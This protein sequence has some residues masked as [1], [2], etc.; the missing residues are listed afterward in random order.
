[1]A[2]KGESMIPPGCTLVRPISEGAFGRVLEIKESSTGKSYA[3]KLIPRLTEADQKR[4]E[5]EVSLLERFR[6]ARIVG[7]H[8]SVV[9]ETYH[10]IVMDLGKRN[11]KDLMIEYESRKKLI[12]LEVAV[13]ISIDI[14]EGLCVMHNHPTHPMAH[15]DLKPE[16]VLL[17]EDNRAMLCDL[18]AAD[19]SGVNVTRSASS[20]GTFEYN[21][22]ERFDDDKTKGTP[23]SDI[24]SLGVMLCRMI[25]GQALFS[26][27][28]TWKL[29][30]AIMDFNESQL[31]SSIPKD[32]RTV[33]V[34]MLDH[35]P[36]SRLTSTQL[37]T[38][39]QLER[40][41]G[42]ETPLSKMKDL[43]I[44]SAS[45]K[46]KQKTKNDPTSNIHVIKEEEKRLQALLDRNNNL[47]RQFLAAT[48]EKT[49]ECVAVNTI[50]DSKQDSAEEKVQQAENGRNKEVKTYSMLS[51]MLPS[52]W[53]QTVSITS[54]D[55]KTHKLTA[56]SVVQTVKLGQDWRTVFTFGLIE[57]EW[58]L[59]IRGSQNPL[60]SVLL[61]FLRFPL[62]D[63]CL[64][65]HCGK[66]DKPIG[67][68]F[69]LSNGR[70]WSQGKELRPAGTNKACTKVGQ[71]AS[72]RVDL[73]KR[74]ARL[75]IDGIA[76]PGFFT[77][78]PFQ[79]C[80]GMSTGYS[81][82]KCAVEI[83][84]LRR[85]DASLIRRHLTI[86]RNTPN[87]FFGTSSLQLFNPEYFT[88]TTTSIVPKISEVTKKRYRSI[89]TH[90][91]T[92][93]VWELKIRPNFDDLCN[94]DLGFNNHPLTRIVPPGQMFPPDR[95]TCVF[96]L[97]DGSMWNI[98]EFKPEGTNKK[99][100]RIG[101]TAAIRVDMN[102]RIAKLC[103][104]D[105]EQPGIFPDIPTSLCLEIE[106]DLD[107]ESL[108]VEV[109]WL[110]RVDVADAPTFTLPPLTALH[111]PLPTQKQTQLTDTVATQSSRKVRTSRAD[112]QST[113]LHQLQALVQQNERGSKDDPNPP[114]PQPPNSA[115]LTPQQSQP[116]RRGARPTA[117]SQVTEPPEAEIVS[118]G[119]HALQQYLPNNTRTVS[120]DFTFQPTDEDRR[121][122]N[123]VK[124]YFTVPITERKISLGYLSSPITNDAYDKTCGSDPT[125]CGGEFV[126]KTG[127]MR[128]FG[129]EFKPAGTNKKCDRVGHI[130]AIRVNMS[131]REARL[132]VD[133]KEQPGV[134]TDIPIQVCL[135]LS[136]A[137]VTTKF[138]VE[139]L[140]LKRFEPAVPLQP[141]PKLENTP[142]F[143]PG[144]N[145]LINFTEQ[146]LKS[147]PTQLIQATPPLGKTP[148]ALTFPIDEGEWE[149]KIRVNHC[150]LEGTLLG[151]SNDPLAGQGTDQS[152]SNQNP[153]TSFFFLASGEQ[154]NSNT[155]FHNFKNKK[156]LCL[157]QTAAIRI[158]ME[159]REATLFVDDEPQSQPLYPLPDVVHI[160]IC[161]G[162]SIP[163]KSVE[164][165]GLKKLRS[166]FK[167]TLPP[168]SP[169]R[170]NGA[171]CLQI[172]PSPFKIF[173]PSILS[174]TTPAAPSQSSTETISLKGLRTAFTKA[175]TEGEW[176]LK[177][178]RVGFTA[179]ASA[180]G[181][182]HHPLPPTTSP[183]PS[184]S[185]PTGVQFDF[186]L[187]SGLLKKDR[188]SIPSAPS[189]NG[190]W[191]KTVQTA[192]I[193]VNMTLRTATLFLDDE[194]QPNIFSDLPDCVYLG[195][196]EP[197][198]V[199][200]EYTHFV[201][202]LWLKRV[203]DPND[204][205]PSPTQPDP[206]QSAILRS[207]STPPV[208]PRPSI[209]DEP[210]LSIAPPTETRPPHFFL[211]APPTHIRNS[212]L[213]PNC[214]ESMP[215][216]FTITKSI[217]TAAP[218]EM[219]Y[220]GVVRETAYTGP[221]TEGEWELKIKSTEKT[222][223]RNLGIGFLRHPFPPDVPKRHLGFF[224][225][226]LAGEFLLANGGLTSGNRP[227]KPAGTNK[228]WERIGQT[229]AIRVNMSMRE[230][231]L[232]VD[233][234]EQPEFFSNIP[235]QIFLGISLDKAATPF[236]F[237][238]VHLKRLSPA[239]PH[240]FT[241]P[242]PT[243]S[244]DCWPGTNSLEVLD[245][246]VHKLTPTQLVQITQLDT[247]T[248]HR[249]AFT[250]PIKEG[251][252]ELKV[253]A[254][255][256]YLGNTY[257]G[258]LR[259]PLPPDATLVLCED[260]PG[261]I[262][263]DFGLMYG[264]QKT[265][266][267][268]IPKLTNRQCIDVGQTAAIQIDMERKEARLFVDDQEQPHPFHPLPDV[269][270]LA[271]STGFDVAGLS[272]EVMWL[273]KLKSA[274]EQSLHPEAPTSSDGTSCLK[275][276][277]SSFVSQSSTILSVTTSGTQ[278]KGR[279]TAF[280]SP[281]TEGEWEFRIKPSGSEFEAYD[282]DL[283]I[284]LGADLQVY[285]QISFVSLIEHLIELIKKNN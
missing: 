8:K 278:T 48:P 193:R 21:S 68:D 154:R 162:F 113:R 262:G 135:A 37:F 44:Q 54:F 178:R 192:A 258:Y 215:E 191:G 269:V 78:I 101:Q 115:P 19:A 200:F 252:W 29:M 139:V 260:Q 34:K 150:A 276:L 243:N 271:I 27:N 220:D 145:S 85:L 67:G 14:A 114:P 72:I 157:G 131:T 277:P 230:A 90:P 236:S 283:Q 4:A 272:L 189:P 218:N 197:S 188:E 245:T 136:H 270:C 56:D 231:K 91:I 104:D 117:P 132:F 211:S 217:L 195:I 133:L 118:R 45:R 74:E 128:K 158:N 9:M 138:E 241:L 247:T 61:G 206:P 30:K 96:H 159:K 32:I 52:T 127:Q 126:L 254:N 232:F 97:C 219:K 196:T 167:H 239:A 51:A 95:N 6:H 148:M 214:L 137:N 149:L 233:E 31:P 77:N 70:M 281:I 1:M 88:I 212:I 179:G 205:T 87:C 2:Q 266:G 83:V 23:A 169:T 161:P 155:N 20:M 73:T 36:A 60:S 203:D 182:H 263:G 111:T 55:A 257:L 102:K 125:G 41:L 163:Q 92:Q 273:K 24:W 170:L 198:K 199:K 166:T 129:K 171:S 147:T 18:G 66:Y 76:Q 168:N 22:P 140:S 284:G 246:S 64:L 35:N 42:P 151:F 201:E 7:L 256:T 106:M 208:H 105:Q 57:G 63:D 264:N 71:T 235:I 153:F 12:P 38:G 142:N 58:E 3:L 267:F 181:F 84:H 109:I 46:P 282:A 89:L 112:L 274:S 65:N 216:S 62:P 69:D 240:P 39:R 248:N 156:C 146:T 99:C 202:V 13:L 249:T 172:L 5:R 165:M 176:E 49:R 160:L 209:V 53:P 103:V 100:D 144:T 268:V 255:H 229:A 15:G 124:T 285:T 174:S 120:F 175:I 152:D 16:N 228:K 86:P 238:L 98:T 234:E 190:G 275:T 123:K 279:K 80:L 121:K 17:T 186:D 253:R 187:I 265:E 244:A 259:H 185:T 26:G 221:I 119:I 108:S 122:N 134:F 184:Q 227:I 213:G 75:L 82:R 237:E 43:L 50:G 107:D 28:S 224:S 164:V 180:I 47:R 194:K 141:P 250:F 177:I 207:F 143:W 33:L 93:G 10:G 81:E 223:L 280:T 173:S 116:Q 40:I 204:P 210:P 79:V 251:E 11:L 261:G 225:R 183:F 59:T 222:V 130:A 226:K 94:V 110:K 25:T 242:C